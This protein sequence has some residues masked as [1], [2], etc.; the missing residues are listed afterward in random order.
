MLLNEHVAEDGLT[1]FAPPAS[2]VPRA[3]LQRRSTA[4]IDP[5]VP[6]WI[7]FAI[8]QASPWS[9]SAAC[10]RRDRSGRD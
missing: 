7:K 2:S 10:A 6:V 3:L 5:S 1:V 9:V 4:P 8:Q